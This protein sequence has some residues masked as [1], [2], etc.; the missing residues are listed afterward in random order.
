MKEAIAEYMKKSLP[1][2]NEEGLEDLG[3]IMLPPR[4]VQD[5]DSEDSP[6]VASSVA[7][8]HT[9]LPS[10]NRPPIDTREDQWMVVIVK[11]IITLTAKSHFI[12]ESC[13][14]AS[15]CGYRTNS[16]RL[17][18]LVSWQYRHT[19]GVML[20]SG[21]SW[22]HDVRCKLHQPKDKDN[23]HAPSSTYYAGSSPRKKSNKV[24]SK[25]LHQRHFWSN[26][27]S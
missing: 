18:W 26:W 9:H 10:P 6:T 7:A 16:H 17:I 23:R 25:N 11:N 3:D 27:S 24:R 1:C 22:W 2:F 14:P 15:S 4:P 5:S 21:A 12:K 13:L 8:P 19:L 20:W